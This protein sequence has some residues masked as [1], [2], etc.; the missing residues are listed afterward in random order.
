MES[1]FY[2]QCTEHGAVMVKVP[3]YGTNKSTENTTPVSLFQW[4]YF[5]FFY[6]YRLLLGAEWA[7][8]GHP[9][10]YTDNPT[11]PNGSCMKHAS[12]GLVA[13][14]VTGIGILLVITSLC[15]WVFSFV[16]AGDA[17]ERVARRFFRTVKP[18]QRFLV[19]QTLDWLG[20]RHGKLKLL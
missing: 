7:R 19:I 3:R 5:F 2:N 12:I 11:F 20:I 10:S 13:F 18:E 4:E 1:Q 17:C 8:F 14:W 9:D 16:A 6:S 15:L